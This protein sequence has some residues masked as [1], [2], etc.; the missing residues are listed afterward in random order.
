[1][2]LI[3]GILAALL[4]LSGQVADAVPGCATLRALTEVRE[5]LT[6]EVQSTSQQLVQMA[7]ILERIETKLDAIES[8]PPVMPVHQESVAQSNGK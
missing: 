2:A 6:D 1:M 3:V 5:Q 4:A 8:R 7:I